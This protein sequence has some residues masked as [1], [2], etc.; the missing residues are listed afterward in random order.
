MAA[1]QSL[2]GPSPDPKTYDFT[3]QEVIPADKLVLGDNANLITFTRTLSDDQA[4]LI[5]ITMSD[6]IVWVQVD[7]EQ[8]RTVQIDG[9]GNIFA[10]GA[11]A[12]GDFVLRGT[13]ARTAFASMP[14]AEICGWAETTQ[15]ET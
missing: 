10:G 13:K 12:D 15:G 3:I 7:S 6:V 14:Q 11:G 4:L 9:N 8:M 2:R 5:P 1:R